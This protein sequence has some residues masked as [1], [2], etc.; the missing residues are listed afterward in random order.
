MICCNDLQAT[1]SVKAAA[2]LA[3]FRARRLPTGGPEGL[4]AQVG[5]DSSE[6]TARDRHLCWSA[7]VL[8][9]GS[10]QAELCS[11]TRV[12]FCLSRTLTSGSPHCFLP[13]CRWTNALAWHSLQATA[14]IEAQGLD[15]TTYI[16]DLGNTTRLFKAW[17]GALPRVMPFYAVKCN[18]EVGCF[19]VLMILGSC[20]MITC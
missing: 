3:E 9:L 1:G 13:S 10:V 6:C 18:P 17:C 15:D 11:G 7:A 16:Y 5:P 19:C 20:S 8:D 2:A 4:A 14:L 12:C